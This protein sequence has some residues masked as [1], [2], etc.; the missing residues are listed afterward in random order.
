MSLSTA[1]KIAQSSF[2]NTA[3]QTAVASNNIANAS[4]TAY[5][6]RSAVLASAA[7]GATVVHTARAQNDALQKQ[8]LL[9]ISK[10]V[11]QDTT[12]A[13]LARIRSTLGGDDYEL[14][15]SNYLATL[16][17]NLQTFADRPSEQ[18]L[19]ETVV[20]N[21]V[22]VANALNSSSADIQQL[23]AEADADIALAVGELNGL[24]K[25]FK[26]Y[27]D[28]VKAGTAAGTDVNDALDQRDKLLSQIS[29]IIGLTTVTRANN[30]MALYTSD[31]TVLF[32]TLPREVTFAPTTTYTA[33]TVGNEIY[34]DGVA[35][36]AGI[37]G[38]TSAQGSIPALLQL[39][40][41]IAP[42][43]QTQLDEMARA[44][45]TMFQDDNLPGL[46]TWMD[47]PVESNVVPATL[48]AGLAASIIVNPDLITA[49]GGNPMLLRDGVNLNQNTDNNASYSTLLDSY[50]AA[51]ATDM[52]FDVGTGIDTNTSILNF[53]TNSI[54]WVEQLRSA[55]VTA[56]DD[57][58]AL[59]SRTQSSLQNVTAVSL[60]EELSLLLDLEQSY[61]ASAKL[62]ATVDEMMTALLQAAG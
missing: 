15:V 1:I 8:N 4:N 24:L 56:S 44:V 6:R 53:S 36:E 61:K 51:F 25:D 3:L 50:A 48:T 30:D 38:N 16:R 10:S 27:N 34:I 12:L 39:R 7:S 45:I 41:D 9:S 11:A 59:L 60:D 23:R 52:T 57:K 32:E 18:S 35:V 5:N 43:Y 42:T 13:G 31:G 46:F 28:Q 26:T 19:A 20:A 29:E 62:V 14:S 37:G 55:A 49:A 33:G 40:D 47:G 58:A 17:D 21:A 54:G 22:D 2:S